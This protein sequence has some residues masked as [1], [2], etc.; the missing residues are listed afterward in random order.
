MTGVSLKRVFIALYVFVISSLLFLQFVFNPLMGKVVKEYYRP[1][2]EEYN[3]KLSQGVFS[4]MEKE[5]RRYPE[6]SWP[7]QLDAMRS[8][9]GYTIALVSIGD[10][11]LS[12]EKMADLHAGRIAVVDEGE[13][14]FHRIADSEYVLKKGP[15]SV[16]EPEKGGFVFI[17]W[18]VVLVIIAL[19]T[20]LWGW[21]SWK[22]LQA[23][24]LAASRFGEG[25]LSARAI[26]P[27]RSGLA[28][29]ANDFNTM[30]RRIEHLIHSHKELT[31][32]VAHELR[33]PLA[34]M[35]FGLEMLGDAKD[36]P[37][38]ESYMEELRTDVAELEE[39]VEELLMLARLERERPQLQLKE[40]EL[41]PFLQDVLFN[42]RQLDD[43]LQCG[44]QVSVSDTFAVPAFDSKYLSRA[45][46]NLV[47]NGYI[48][49]EKQVMLVAEQEGDDLLLHIDD[50]GPGIPKDARQKVFEPFAR[51]DTS[52]SR[53][54][55]GYG[56]G[57]AIV[58]RIV[59]WHR[60]T[61]SVAESPC[62]G[63]RFTI[64]LHGHHGS[65]G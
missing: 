37:E 30:A 14:L 35:R 47:R 26:L 65:E 32:A 27:K 55:G 46:G 57:L 28:P 51:L 38:R 25:D 34:R 11:A 21:P 52:R 6:S 9:F 58:A 19:L 56:L 41:Q 40:H 15:F 4:L 42:V 61:I 5:L 10:L 29:L 50:D 7:E 31:N 2:I 1:S 63:A 48:H 43:R 62:G 13:Y 49:A 33:T 23:I 54:S 16:L 60:G 8:D 39:M 24:S 12:P 44:L 17:I 59:E 3:R 36:S 20:V 53:G 18:L 64:R 45:V 22:R